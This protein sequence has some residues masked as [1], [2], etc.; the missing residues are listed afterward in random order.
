MTMPQV[1]FFNA[2]SMEWT[3][4][5]RFPAIQI[6]ALETRATHPAASV[7]LVRLEEG[8]RIE[9]H[10][11]E[12][13]SETVYQLAGQGTLTHGDAQTPVATGRGVSIPPGLPHS[14]HNTGDVPL[15]LIAIHTPPTR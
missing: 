14:L 6:K 5:E 1:H 12:L 15:E 4:H 10:T 9:T 13:E 7:M 3:G 11:H 2:N 8:G